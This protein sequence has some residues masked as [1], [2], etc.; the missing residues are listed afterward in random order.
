MER[1]LW[2]WWKIRS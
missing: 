2:K 1:N